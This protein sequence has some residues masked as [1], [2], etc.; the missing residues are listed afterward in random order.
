MCVPREYRRWRNKRRLSRPL[1]EG[2]EA[3]EGCC[4]SKG[5]FEELKSVLT[6]Q[7][8]DLGASLRVS[9]VSGTVIPGYEV[10]NRL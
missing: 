5:R 3:V 8:A 10:I 6:L 7:R 4:R 9:R 2:L 1:E